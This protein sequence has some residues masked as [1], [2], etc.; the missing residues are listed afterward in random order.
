VAINIKAGLWKVSMKMNAKG[1]EVNPLAN[2]TPEKKKM[3]M[4]MVAKNKV[5]GGSDGSM[6][7]CYSKKM[8]ENPESFAKK[9]Y[10]KFKLV[11]VKNTSSKIVTNMKCEDGTVADLTMNMIDSENYSSVLNMEKKGK[12]SV[13]NSTGKFV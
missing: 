11:N 6:Q 12:K 7:I 3:M 8:I 2:M 13:M 9:T 4:D 5:G 10:K 1:K